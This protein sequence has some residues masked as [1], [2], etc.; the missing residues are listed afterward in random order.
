MEINSQTLSTIVVD[1]NTTITYMGQRSS[2]PRG[3]ATL[4]MG[5]TVAFFHLSGKTPMSIQVFIISDRKSGLYWKIIFNI[6]ES[7]IGRPL[8]LKVLMLLICLINISCGGY[9]K[10]SFGK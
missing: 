3:L 10:C 1:S 2:G 4:G 9:W 7:T 5:I 8:D 6:L